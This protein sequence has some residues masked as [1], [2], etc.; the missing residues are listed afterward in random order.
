MSS[1]IDKRKNHNKRS[2][3][4]QKLLIEKSLQLTMNET[5]LSSF[6]DIKDK[7]HPFDIIAF[8]GGDIVS[9]VISTLESHKVGAGAFTHIGMVVTS[10]ILDH[11]IINES[12]SPLEP[13]RLYIFESTFSFN[14]KGISEGPPNLITGKG[15]LGVQ[16]RDLEAIIPYY[17]TNENTKIAW[18]HL[19]NNPFDDIENQDLLCKQFTNFFLNYEDRLYEL[20]LESL[21]AA[22]FPCLRSIRKFKD[23]VFTAVYKSLYKL[24]ISNQN[25]GPAGWQFC[26][27]LIANV[28]QT[29]GVIPNSFN[30]QDVLPVD[31]FGNDEDGIPRLLDPPIYIKDWDLPGKPAVHYNLKIS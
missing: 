3:K 20:N 13:D 2:K 7:I 12:N 9:D 18:C 11:W 1:H 8:R 31:F 14:I 26:S 10:D 5:N 27:E 15:K 4:S 30:P 28:Y 29:I 22:L 25:V 21:L 19:N 24:G 23:N 17:I 6:S 16:L